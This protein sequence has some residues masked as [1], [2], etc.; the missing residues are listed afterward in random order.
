MPGF[1]S[2]V[3]KAGQAQFGPAPWL[4]GDRSQL[5]VRIDGK[6]VHCCAFDVV[7]CT[8]YKTPVLCDAIRERLEEVISSV[9]AHR[10]ALL[11]DLEIRPD[12][13]HLIAGI[14]P[15]FGIHRLVKAV[16]ARSAYLLRDEFPELRSRMPSMWTNAYLVR[17][18]GGA[19]EQT[20]IDSYLAQQSTR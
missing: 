4:H 7:W 17:T 8:Q 15:Q 11:L 9:L 13:V 12:H 3:G 1:P 10:Q 14:S 18:I 5:P 6:V 16:K 2:P 19:L 20:V